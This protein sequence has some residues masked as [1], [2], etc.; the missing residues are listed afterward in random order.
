MILLLNA[1]PRIIGGCEAAF[2][3]FLVPLYYWKTVEKP[4]T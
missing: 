1:N 2:N 4:E 3:D